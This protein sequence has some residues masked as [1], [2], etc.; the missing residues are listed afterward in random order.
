VPGLAAVHF[1]S[2]WL[3]PSGSGQW[4]SN[5]EPGLIVLGAVFYRLVPWAGPMNL[6]PA[7]LAA[8]I[9]T[10]SAMATLGLVARRLV[11]GKEALA[12]ALISGTATTT[13]AVSG[14]AL[15]P[16]GPDQ[17]FLAAAMLGLA[18]GRSGWAALAFAG[19][20]V[21]RLPLGAVAVITGMW[22]SRIR[23]SFR[24]ALLI[25]LGCA[26]GVAG[27]LAYSAAFWGG[28]PDS[29]Y[30]ATGGG[31][32][33]PFLDVR[34]IA[35]WRLAV[36]IAG[37]IIS[38]GRGVLFGAPFLLALLPGLRKAW[39]VA[40]AWVRS[41]SL[42]GAL[43]LLIQLKANRFSGGE[44]FWSYRYPLE[45]L[46]LLAPLLVLAWAQWTSQTR[47]RRAA[48]FALVSLAIGLQAVGAICFRGPYNAHPWLLADLLTVLTG[49]SQWGA[50]ALLV[51]GIGVGTFAYYRI[52]RSRADDH[53]SSR[54]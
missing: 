49:G 39:A 23:R 14:T 42:G 47:R 4:V 27:Y 8:A 40:P 5:R 36:N 43:Y 18:G 44:R 51:A 10:A 35:W 9:I 19:S 46:T 24:P 2:P 48:F 15:W 41:S 1:N 25:G 38:P 30:E 53:A 54:T 21:V 37:T 32:V 12:V 34:P 45:T 26:L 13:W 29:Q 3:I 28:G 16:H 22:E 7:S 17:F 33:R 52:T 20:L 31:F 6:F 50:A 11:S